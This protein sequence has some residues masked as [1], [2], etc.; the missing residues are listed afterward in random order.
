[1]AKRHSASF[2]KSP[3]WA[4]GTEVLRLMAMGLEGPQSA[5]GQGTM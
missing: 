1:M 5:L 4:E 3:S 2:G